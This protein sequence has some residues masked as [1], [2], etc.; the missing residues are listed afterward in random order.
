MNQGSQQLSAI[1]REIAKMIAHDDIPSDP[2]R[3]A[4]MEAH[5]QHAAARIERRD[6]RVEEPLP[7]SFV[8]P[9][10]GHKPMGL[11]AQYPAMTDIR[12]AFVQDVARSIAAALGYDYDDCRELTVR[13]IDGRHLP[14][15]VD[16]ID[17]A[18][19][20]IAKCRD[21]SH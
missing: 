9:V 8:G 14:P 18:E 1:L 7:A 5:L 13:K 12:A 2:G 19:A 20:A 3:R 6:K 10:G 16:F 21:A 15:Q 17:A 4:A 11:D